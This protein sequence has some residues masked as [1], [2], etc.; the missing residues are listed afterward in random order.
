MF[1]VSKAYERDSVA[2]VDV[3]TH[4]GAGD[5]VFLTGSSGAGKTTFLKLLFRELRPSSG[6][7][8]VNGTNIAALPWSDVPAIRRD[9]GVVFQDFRLLMQRPVLDNVEIG[10]RIQGIAP[11]E[12]KTTAIRV[13]QQVGLAH[14]LHVLPTKLSGG[15]QQRVA[16]ARALVMVPR[17]LL[18]DE[19]TGNLDPELSLEI[20][21]LLESVNAH[22]TTVV[23]ATHDEDVIRLLG[24]RRIV[25]HQG[26][27]LDQ[28][29]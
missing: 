5:F 1:H 22:G 21:R 28:G 11:T 17:L 13:L 8:L 23:V 27:I 18:A 7:I 15:E 2:L 24:K 20:M 4:V 9:I 6:Q 3:S 14:K 26:R 25:L 10:L 29:R 12:R 19:P 16:I